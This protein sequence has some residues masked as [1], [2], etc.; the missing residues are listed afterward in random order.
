MVIKITL[1]EKGWYFKWYLLPSLPGLYKKPL[2]AP[3]KKYNLSHNTK[4]RLTGKLHSL[5]FYNKSGL[6]R[7]WRQE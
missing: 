2:A 3:G 6:F 5:T 1:T 4:K 7:R